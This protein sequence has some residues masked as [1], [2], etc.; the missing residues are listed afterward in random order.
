MPSRQTHVLIAGG[1]V[2]ALEAALALQATASELVT[3]ELIAPELHFW[4]RPLS[5]AEPFGLGESTR[6]ELG[7]LAERAGATYTPGSLEGVDAGAHMA[8]TSVGDIPYD[9]LLVATGARSEQAVDGATL[10]F[11]GP[12]DV[13]PLTRLLR[14]I[15]SGAVRRTAFVVPWGATWALPAY[16]LALMTAARLEP[17]DLEGTEVVLVTT[18]DEPLELFGPAAS[19]AVNGLLEAYGIE[20][21][22]GVYPRSVV[23]DELWVVP[24]GKIQAD[25]VVALPRLRGPRIDGLP[26][27]VVRLHPG[28][29]VRTG[30]R[31]GRCLRGRRL[32]QLPAQAGRHRGAAGADR[33]TG[34]RGSS[35]SPAWS[36]GRSR[37]CCEGCSSPAGSR[38]SSAATSRQAS[39]SP[40]RRAP[41]RSGGPRRRSSAATS[42]RSWQSSPAPRRPTPRP[43]PRGASRWRSSSS[44]TRSSGSGGPGSPRA[45]RTARASGCAR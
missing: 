39:P 36:R 17:L 38:S 9:V 23:D 43:R 10:T 45:S 12:A 28:R 40:P 1:G 32:H 37:P 21:H 42:G 22:T 11:R 34:H 24:A 33:G 30:H 7:T 18:E 2:A 31:P 6:Y 14:Q 41:T 27:N 16:E 13:E 25:A 35:R 8:R 44:R 4:Y 3:V 29:R 19:E 20:L 26:Q 5:V 15:E